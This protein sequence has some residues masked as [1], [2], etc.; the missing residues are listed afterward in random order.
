MKK[1]ITKEYITLGNDKSLLRKVR[2][3]GSLLFTT[4]IDSK[5]VLEY[6]ERKGKFYK[7]TIYLPSM[8]EIQSI[9]QHDSTRRDFLTRLLISNYKRQMR[10]IE[11]CQLNHRKP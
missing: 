10:G 2:K 9:V 7:A 5:K 11:R 3:F 8:P 4:R 6:W 1:Y